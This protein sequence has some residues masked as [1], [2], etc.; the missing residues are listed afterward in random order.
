MTQRILGTASA[1][2]VRDLVDAMVKA[3]VARALHVINQAIDSGS[4][5]RQFGQQVVEHLRSVMLAQTASAD[6]LQASQDDKELFDQQ[7]QSISR[8]SLLRAVRAF[9]DAVNNYTGGWQPQLVLS[10]P[11]AAVYLQMQIQI[12]II[13]LFLTVMGF[14]FY[15]FL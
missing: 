5:P 3:E 11:D 15:S 10:G 9:N 2:A 7:A 4:D 13:F 8:S 6:L 12:I 1:I 14:F